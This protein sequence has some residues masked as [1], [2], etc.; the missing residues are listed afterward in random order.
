MTRV[1]ARTRLHYW[2]LCALE[3]LADAQAAAHEADNAARTLQ[4][5]WES[6]DTPETL[7][8]R[9]SSIRAS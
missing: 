7:Y 3:V 9:R 6:H 5:R 8:S 1:S 2:G 4:F